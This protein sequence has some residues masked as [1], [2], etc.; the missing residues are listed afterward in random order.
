MKSKLHTLIGLLLLLLSLSATAHTPPPGARIFFI[1]IEEGA[2][3][4]SPFKIRFGIE[5]FGITPAGTKGKIRH[6]AGHHHLL[7]NV[8]QLPDLD[9]PIPRDEQHLHFD[10]GE[11]ETVLDLPPGTHTLQLLLGDENHEPQDPALMSEKITVRVK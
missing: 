9:S 11:T 1:G 6:H 7:I 10:N 4:K 5:G 2:V 3:V 8:E